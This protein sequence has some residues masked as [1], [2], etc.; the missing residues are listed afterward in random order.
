[1]K[2]KI[3]STLI[4]A[5]VAAGLLF[6]AGSKVKQALDNGGLV[7]LS[8]TTQQDIDQTPIEI[9]SIR[10]IGQWEFLSIKTEE[11]VD[12]VKKGFFFDDRIVCIYRGTLSLGIDMEKCDSTWISAQK[13]DSIALRAAGS[14]TARPEFHQRGRDQCVF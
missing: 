9:N 4:L 11:L 13:G 2:K 5:V 8:L 10:R 12:S 14:G 1:M 3:I 6:W 7:N